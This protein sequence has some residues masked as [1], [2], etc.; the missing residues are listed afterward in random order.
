[1]GSFASYAVYLWRMYL[2]VRRH[3]WLGLRH[4]VSEHAYALAVFTSMG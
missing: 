1:M 2:E 4:P 3:A